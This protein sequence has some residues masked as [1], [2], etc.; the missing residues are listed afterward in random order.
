MKVSLILFILF[1]LNPL[2]SINT[3]KLSDDKDAIIIWNKGHKLEWSD[4]TP[5]KYSVGN[6]GAASDVKIKYQI[7]KYTSNDSS[8]IFIYSCF[9][10]KNSWAI[11]KHED[12]L[13][14]EHERHHFD[15]CEIYARKLRKETGKM[16][17]YTDDFINLTYKTIREEN[18]EQDLYDKET[19]HSLNKIKQVEWDKKIDNQLKTLDSF[20]NMHVIVKNNKSK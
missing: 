18:K 5:T 8:D 4:Y 1:F 13:G 3:N 17:F 20:S 11:V 7:V 14:L 6:D 19:N 9:N 12:S 15:L 2:L 10:K 16:N